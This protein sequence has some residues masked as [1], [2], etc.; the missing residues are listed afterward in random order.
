MNPFFVD[1]WFKSYTHT[2]ASY[3]RSKRAT[4]IQKLGQNISR[5]DKLSPVWNIKVSFDCERYSHQAEWMDGR[6]SRDSPFGKNKK[7][8]DHLDVGGRRQVFAW[9]FWTPVGSTDSSLDDDTSWERLNDG[10][11][12]GSGRRG[13]GSRVA[14][15]APSVGQGKAVLAFRRCMN[16]SFLNSFW[17][18]LK[19]PF[20]NFRY[21]V[22]QRTKLS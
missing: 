19:L 2:Y 17:C 22:I 13:D 10:E 1:R 18:F 12:S 4:V 11:R 14:E 5:H 15:P 6:E 9:F 21:C 8:W 3:F 7:S 16:N 20:S